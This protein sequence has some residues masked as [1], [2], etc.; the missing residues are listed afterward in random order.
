VPTISVGGDA[1]L[2][3]RIAEME[4]RMAEQDATMRRVLAMLIDWMEK[5]NHSMAARM[6]DVRA[7]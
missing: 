5:E 3:A 4:V 7:A 2:Q 1:N 6:R